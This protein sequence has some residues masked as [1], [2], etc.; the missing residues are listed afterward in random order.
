[1]FWLQLVAFIYQSN[2]IS[3][4]CSVVLKSQIKKNDFNAVLSTRFYPV[5]RS[6]VEFYQSISLRTPHLTFLW[7]CHVNTGLQGISGKLLKCSTD[8]EF[9]S[10][11]QLATASSS[12]F[13]TCR[14]S[15]TLQFRLMKLHHI[16]YFRCISAVNSKSAKL[17]LSLNDIMQL[18]QTLYAYGCSKTP[19]F[20]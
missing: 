14:H 7:H 9:N 1:M 15:S 10:Q 11:C 17:Q 19:L 16:P 20:P 2:L 4:T 3:K 13:N 12:D 18:V 6:S 5:Q 8:Q